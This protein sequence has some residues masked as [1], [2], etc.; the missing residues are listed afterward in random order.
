MGA[1]TVI[2]GSADRADYVRVPSSQSAG[3]EFDAKQLATYDASNPGEVK[4]TVADDTGE[5]AG[6]TTKDEQDSYVELYI[7]PILKMA[8][9]SGSSPIL[10]EEVYPA[11]VDTCYGPLDA[12]SNATGFGYALR[13]TTNWILIRTLWLTDRT[14]ADSPS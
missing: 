11:G 9:A 10:L 2:P 12:G 4:K 14:P 8:R 7:G 1:N 5:I 3:S 13:I 6:I